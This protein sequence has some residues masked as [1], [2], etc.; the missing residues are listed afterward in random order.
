MVGY[1][2]IDAL[3]DEAAAMISDEQFKRLTGID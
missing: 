2:W 3:K 1:G